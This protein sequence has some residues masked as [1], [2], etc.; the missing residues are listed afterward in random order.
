MKLSRAPFLHW[1]TAALGVAAL[2]GIMRP[3]LATD[4]LVADRLSNSV[5]RYSETGELLGTVLTDNQ[6]IFQAV[7]LA[8][9]PDLTNLYVSSFQ[10]GRVMRYDYDYE[11]G[12][13]NNP[14]PFATG[15]SGPNAILFNSGGDTVYV[16]NL[17]G[18]G[19]WRFNIDGSS[20]G[21]PLKFPQPPM[22]SGQDF[23]QLSGLAFAPNGNLLVGAFKDYPAQQKGAVLEWNGVDSTLEFLVDPA[24]S[25][26]GASGLLVHEDH[27]YVTG[28]FASNIQRFNLD[29]GEHDPSFSVTGLE[30]PQ[31]LM[32]APNGD[33]FLAGVL[34]VAN[35]QGRIAHY[36]FNG[37]LIGDGVFASHGG[38]GFTEATALIAVP[39]RLPGDFNNNGAVDAADYTVWRNNL[40]SSYHLHGNGDETGASRHVVDLADFQMWKQN[41]GMVAGGQSLGGGASVVPEPSSLLLA[42]A[43]AAL[44]LPPRRNR[45]HALRSRHR[46]VSP[47]AGFTLVEVL[48]TI[49]IIAVLI[50]LLLPAVQAARESARRI[51]CANNMKQLGVA[52]H[53]Y[54]SAFACLPSAAISKQYPADPHHP[55]TFYRWSALAQL[56][57]YME[58]ANLHDLID[59]SLPLYM[60]G[61]GYPFAETNKFGISKILPEFLCA[62]DHGGMIKEGM[63]PTNYAVCSGS[64]AGGGTPFDTD[65]LFYVNSET[66]YARIGDG[67]SH[68]IALSESLLGEETPR[69]ASFAFSPA[70]PSRNYK[71][72]LSF[73]GP[74]DLTDFTCDGSQNYN[75]P[76]NGNDPRGFAWCSG[77]YRCA[78]YNHRYPPNSDKY[79]CIT[80]VTID[81]SPEPIRLYAAYGWRTARSMHPGGINVLLADGSTHFLADSVN[82][83]VWQGLSTRNSADV[84]PTFSP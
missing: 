48:V 1:L 66:T 75:S 70:G 69:N 60:P 33:G 13:A 17:G 74:P 2:T 12:T 42:I 37:N 30:F 73:F 71:F 6:N 22:P 61:A 68:T 81:P 45:R 5:Y 63:G 55:Y 14:V 82:L 11:S 41:F 80:S 35:G 43:A 56:L 40:R 27:L 15:L 79:D 58:R 51:Q 76:A 84:S 62:S 64:G 4:V 3:V 21:P 18:I 67:S 50:A 34:G 52:M 29:D 24:P 78:M 39:D 20:A 26:D 47:S 49:A 54:T 65:G 19:V 83:P 53:G 72:V 9:S 46:T 7:G 57:P 38:G 31:G 16:S 77:E 44:G 32:A 28:M 59:R 36:D 25:L 8:L 10:N 23:R